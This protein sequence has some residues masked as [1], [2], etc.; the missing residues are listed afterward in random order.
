MKVQ[1]L[2]I[3]LVPILRYLIKCVGRTRPLCKFCCLQKNNCTNE[4]VCKMYI[5]QIQ[6]LH[7]RHICICTCTY[8][9]HMLV[10]Y[11]YTVPWMQMQTPYT[12]EFSLL[13]MKRQ[14]TWSLLFVNGKNIS[15]NS[16]SRNAPYKLWR[17]KAREEPSSEQERRLA[18]RL[19]F[20]EQS[21]ATEERGEA[22]GRLAT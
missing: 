2:C 3:P 12:V 1:L 17:I 4:Q 16:V 15:I 21:T 5:F 11:V 14:Q 10:T 6:I 7:V 9:F 18:G 22:C 20:T 13:A 19:A 8:V